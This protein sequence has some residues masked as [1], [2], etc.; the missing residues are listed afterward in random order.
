MTTLG[1]KA[2]TA[3]VDWQRAQLAATAG[4]Q[5]RA[6]AA[7]H[8]RAAEATVVAPLLARQT[9][10]EIMERFA[11]A[12]PPG[13]HLNS[14]TV[15]ADSALLA[16]VDIADPDLLGSALS[17]D[18]LLRRLR[19]IGQSTAPEGVRVTLRADPS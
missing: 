3:V 17:S 4:S 14:I 16:E 11:Q 13:A 6:S 7:W 2:A 9:V 18:P 10:S 19:T 8:E 15:R 12:L 5:L 1:A